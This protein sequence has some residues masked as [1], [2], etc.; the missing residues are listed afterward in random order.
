MSTEENRSITIRNFGRKH[1][2]AK[3]YY[4]EQID[5]LKARVLELEKKMNPVCI[6]CGEKAETSYRGHLFCVKCATIAVRRD[7]DAENR[8]HP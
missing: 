3:T 6:V 5:D 7:K 1:C 2:M 8:I 4:Q